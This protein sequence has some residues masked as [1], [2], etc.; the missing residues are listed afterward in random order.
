MDNI[1]TNME[2]D[3]T[4][5]HRVEQK[6]STKHVNM[7]TNRNM[8]TNLETNITCHHGDQYGE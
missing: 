3:M 2:A 1:K 5:K 4:G 8:D 7:E 6:R